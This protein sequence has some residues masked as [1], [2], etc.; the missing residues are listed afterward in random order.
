MKSIINGFRYDTDK[1]ELIGEASHGYAGD[2]SRWQAGL[3]RTKRARR[4]FLAGSGGPMTTWGRNVDQH[5]MTSGEGIR[6]MSKEDALAWAEQNLSTEQI[7]A[8]FAE[9]IKDA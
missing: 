1:A 3:Y 7:E 9:D 2:F 8:G 4:F 5:T 6:V